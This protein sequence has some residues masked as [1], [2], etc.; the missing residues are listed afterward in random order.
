ML[1]LVSEE[2]KLHALSFQQ[3]FYLLILKKTVFFPDRFSGIVLVNT[4]SGVLK[5][6]PG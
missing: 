3:S 4:Y 5:N 2:N 1:G 6:S